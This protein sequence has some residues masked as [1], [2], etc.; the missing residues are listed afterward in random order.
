[1]G[2]VIDYRS[3]RNIKKKKRKRHGIHPLLVVLILIAILSIYVIAKKGVDHIEVSNNKSVYDTIEAGLIN[4]QTEIVIATHDDTEKIHEE[5]IKVLNAHPELF[6]ATGGFS[7]T[8]VTNLTIPTYMLRADSRCRQDDIPNMMAAL[9]A[10]VDSI[11]SAANEKCNSDYEKA[12]FVHDLIVLNCTY[13]VDTYIDYLN[14]PDDG[15]SLSYTSYGCLVNRK[16]VCEGYSK[17][18]KLILNRLNIECEVVSG[19]A[20]NETGSEA[21]AW[22]YIKLDDGYYFVDVTWDDPVVLDGFET[23]EIHRDYFCLNSEMMSKDHFP[24]DNEEVP[25][26]DGKAYIKCIGADVEHVVRE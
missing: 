12:A 6:W 15:T 21:H 3:Y 17:A 9:N 2:K 16:A 11:V 13:D 5:A 24:D 1:M 23:N 26:C 10:S 20:T 14:N 4:N 19:T 18:Y 8:G 7:M 22:N 25:Y